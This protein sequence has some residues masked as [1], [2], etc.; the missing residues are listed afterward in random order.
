MGEVAAFAQVL[1][2]VGMLKAIQNHVQFARARFGTY[3]TMDFVVVLLGYALSGER[4]LQAFYE[5]LSPFADVFMA[6]FERHR[7]PD[8]STLS[9]FL[10]AL[11]QTTVEALRTQFQEDLVARTPFA[12]VG[13]LWDRCDQPYVVVDVDGTRQAARQRALPHLPSLPAPHRRFDQ[14]AA[15]GYKGRKRGEVVRTRTTLLQAHTHQFLGTFGGA[16]N[17]DYR[18]ELKRA[19]QVITRYATTHKLLPSQILVRLDG[20]Y[21]NAAVLRDVLDMDLGII[22]RSRDYGLLDL[23]AVQAVLARPPV[24]ICTHAESGAARALYDCP[25]IPLTAGGPRVRLIV[26]SHPATSTRTS[27]GK[28]RDGM[29]Y[30]LFV[31]RLATPAFSAKDVLDLYLHR[32]SF[33]TVLADEDIEQDP[34]RWCSHTPCGQEFWQILCQWVWNLR[35]E[36]GQRFSPAA[37]RTTEFAPACEPEPAPSAPES[38]PVPASEPEPVLVYGPPQWAQR[39]FTGGFPG[40]AFPLQPDGNLLCPAHHPLYPQE[41][42]S[43]RDGSYRVLYAARIGDCRSCHL[44]ASCLESM[45][46]K[47]PRRVSAVFWP[48]SS[49]QV[50][51]S[52]SVLAPPP[53]TGCC[54]VLWRDWPRC[55]IRRTWLKVVRSQKVV[56][57][58]AAPPT[59]KQTAGTN[60]SVITRAQR[61]HWRLSW[62]QRLARNA[63]PATAPPL[64]LTIH[65]LPA[66]FA[67]VYGFGLSAVA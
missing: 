60:V 36:L 46:T 8:R 56:M 59:E 2:H 66:T 22:G 13:G 61:A 3:D 33:E 51:S 39:S 20:L 38:S 15:P 12:S 24:E 62:E 29:V 32:G 63:R 34:D 9:R 53:S 21:G 4:T 18:E 5:R 65:G 30:E 7:L 64:T 67:T 26:A 27:I 6:L 1:S 50:L 40:S 54:P 58:M 43:E 45:D 35:L 16:G 10:S 17:G 14:V 19:I 41:R 47:K 23:A 42:R 48:I 57:T 37:M 11:D 52:T 31:T 28:K 25:D 49:T 44:R 55:H